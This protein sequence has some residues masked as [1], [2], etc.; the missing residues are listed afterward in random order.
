MIVG[1]GPHLRDLLLGL[2]HK[3]GARREDRFEEFLIGQV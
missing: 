1:Q 2:V 3:L